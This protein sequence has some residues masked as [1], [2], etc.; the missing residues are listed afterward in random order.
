MLSNH[1]AFLIC[2]V[3]WHCVFCT[4]FGTR[5]SNMASPSE[6]SDAHF[7]ED[8]EDE[9]CPLYCCMHVTEA[10]SKVVKFSEKSLAKFRACSN[11]WRELNCP[12]SAIPAAVPPEIYTHPQRV[13]PTVQ[14]NRRRRLNMARM[15][16]LAK[17]LSQ[18]QVLL[19][20]HRDVL[21]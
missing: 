11:C 7:A 4:P 21:D 5:H 19:L 20:L 13:H 6:W 17:C 3:Q 9:E 18:A 16:L 14:H 1:N 10:K 15:A 2:T 8:D 12:E